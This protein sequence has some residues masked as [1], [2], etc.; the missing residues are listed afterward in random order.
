MRRASGGTHIGPWL[1]HLTTPVG[2][3]GF[4]LMHRA[5]LLGP[6]P[7][8]VIV[9]LLAVT[10]VCNAVAYLVT[11]R[12]EPGPMRM[13]LRLSVAAMSTTVILYST[14]WGPVIAIGYVL[15]VSDVLRTDGSQAW[16]RGMLWSLGAIALGQF[17]IAVGLAPSVLSEH[18]SH[19]VAIGNAAC[20]VIVMYSL[21]TTAAATEAAK[22][23]IGK[24]R[25]H[26]RSLVQHAADVIAVIDCADLTIRYVSPS[27]SALLGFDAP[28]CIGMTIHELLGNSGH[29]PDAPR[30]VASIE[31]AGGTRTHELT[32]R[33][34]D[35]SPRVVEI[36]STLRNDGMIIGNVHDVTRQRA[37]EHEL[38]YKARHDTL[39]GLMNRGALLEAVE[40]H[41]AGTVVADRCSVLFVDLDGFKEVNDELGHERGDEVLV[42][43]ARRI[44]GAVPD[45]ALTGRLGG[46][47]FL[48]VLQG[49]TNQQAS[50]I[51][52]RILDALERPWQ[53][54]P[55]RE[56]SAS[57]GVATTGP[58]PEAAEDILRRADEAMYDA[59]RQGKNRYALAPVD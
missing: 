47:E 22:E 9:A 40:Q 20:L 35:G 58:T 54:L 45:G 2:L 42:E 55:G 33:H 37:L 5:D 31:A 27:I 17:A 10:G 34:R 21:G 19:A 38:R 56:I 26:F 52:L 6:A 8:W 12:M 48:V 1:P 15:G 50:A 16:W 49:T 36:T 32:V 46:D 57:I 44:L 30:Y 18:V 39:T 53:S 51:A 11:T 24:E 43:A 3:L 25:E 4:Y 13:H 23:V 28:A 29:V 7:F 14:G 59:K 41:L